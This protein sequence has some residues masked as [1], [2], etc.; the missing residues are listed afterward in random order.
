MI[1]W[2]TVCFTNLDQGIKMIIFESILTTFIVSVV[3]SIDRAVAKISSSFNP[4]HHEQILLPKSV[5][6]TVV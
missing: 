6:Q 4:D 2:H 3:S 5:K 1:Q